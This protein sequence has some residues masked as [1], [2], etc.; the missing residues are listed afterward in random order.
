VIETG[1][2]DT[3]TEPCLDDAYDNQPHG[4]GV[5]NFH[6]IVV[7]GGTTFPAQPLEYLRLTDDPRANNPT[8]DD[9]FGPFTWERVQP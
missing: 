3:S 6:R 9:S 2:P 4:Y 8:T 5:P 1:A 7:H